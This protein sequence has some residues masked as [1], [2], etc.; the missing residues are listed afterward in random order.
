MAVIS[1]PDEFVGKSLQDLRGMRSEPFRAD[2]LSSM[3]GIGESIPFQQGQTFSFNFN[4]PGSGEQQFLQKA[5]K[6]GPG[7]SHSVLSAASSL[8]ASLPE[9]ESKYGQKR[10]QLEGEKE[11]IKQRYQS[12][13][14]E[15]TRREGQEVDVANKNI[16]REFGKRGIPLS[17]GV[18]SQELTNVQDPINKYYVNQ[19]TGATQS[20]DEALRLLTSDIANTFTE[21][22]E[23]KRVIRNAMAQLQFEADQAAANRALQEQQIQLEKANQQISRDRY[24]NIEL[25]ESRLAQQLQSLALLPQQKTSISSASRPSSVSRPSLDSL[26]QSYVRGLS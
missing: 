20:Q 9:I 8:E 2:V 12:L 6:M 19:R 10:T 16:S 17:S 25:P 3:L 1:V 24:Q 21:E 13:L 23:A 26:F 22:T 14:D 11:P 5:F 4:D 15:L 7:M 18:F